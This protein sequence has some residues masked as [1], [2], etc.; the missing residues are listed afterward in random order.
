MSNWL[1]LSIFALVCWGITGN[2]QKLS[3]N[4]ITTQFSFLGFALAFIPI[5]IVTIFLFPR[6][7]NLS[8]QVLVLGIA[9]GVLNSL[10]VL[11]SFAAFEAGAKSSVAVPIMYLYPL[12]T[13]VLARLFLHEQIPPA[14]W[15]GIFLAPVA[16]WL[17]SKE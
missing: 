4:Y 5:A 8:L 6:E 12:I 10:G 1:I 13:V 7:T 14:H 9:G 2:T 11:T 16:A 3:T 17:L 15:A